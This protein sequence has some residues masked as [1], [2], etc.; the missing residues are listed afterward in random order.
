[1][2][3]I[4]I[5]DDDA[6]M[7]RLLSHFLQRKGFETDSA[8]TASKGLAKFAEGHFDLVLCDFRLG[9]KDGRDV[10][11]EIKKQ[12]PAAIVIIITGYSDIKMAVEVMRYGAFDY[13]TKPLIPEE[14]LNL[15]NKA[16]TSREP[17]ATKPVQD[18]NTNTTASPTWNAKKIILSSEE[19]LVGVSPKTTDVYKQVALVAPTEYSV[20]IYGESGTGKEVIAQ[21]IHDSSNRKNKPFMAVDCGTLSREL[22]AS[23]LFGHIKGSFT[24]ALGDKEGMFEG[25]DGGTLFLD[26]VSNLP[27]DVQIT[28]LR[29]IQERKF[30]R[31]GS[32]KDLPADVRVIVASNE[33]LQDS[34]RK[35]KFRED[36]YHR[37][38]EFSISLPPLRERKEDIALFGAFFLDKACKELGKQLEGFDEEVMQLFQSYSWPG[39]LREFRNVIRRAALLT[40]SGLITANVLPWEIIGNLGKEAEAPAASNGNGHIIHSHPPRDLKDATSQAEYETI[41]NVLKEVKFNKTKAAELLKIDRKTL[42]NKMRQYEESNQSRKH[43]VSVK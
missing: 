42:Y 20:I 3:K 26:E 6:D 4:L 36:L 23:E 5:I 10:L 12:D 17:S 43:D 25:A 9:E 32:N 37:F 28:L 40:P 35:G 13:I 29:V 33:N 18:N 38:N 31:V 2:K 39:N 34:Y 11:Q 19:Y 22:A 16:L 8:P 24:G 7:C 1:M 30:K 27:M 21:T 14:I 15:I 41:M